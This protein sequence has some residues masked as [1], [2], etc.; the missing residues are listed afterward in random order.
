MDIDNLVLPELKH[1]AKPLDKILL[2]GEAIIRLLEQYPTVDKIERVIKNSIGESPARATI[3]KHLVNVKEQI[4]KQVRL[5]N[6]INNE[7]PEPVISAFKILMDYGE[8]VANINL[9]NEFKNIKLERE[10][11]LAAQKKDLLLVEHLKTQLLLAHN[12]QDSDLEI[13][14]Q[15]KEDFTQLTENNVQKEK[16]NNNNIKQ[17]AKQEAQNQI[18][19]TTLKNEQ[20]QIKSFETELTNSKLQA[21][22]FEHERDRLIFDVELLKKEKADLIAKQ[23]A[24]KKNIEQMR[25]MMEQM[26][27]TMQNQIKES[28]KLALQK[29]QKEDTTQSKF[30]MKRSNLISSRIKQSVR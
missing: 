19:N 26:S 17:L 3:T 14:K 7:L 24:N 8:T 1:L 22:A 10:T 29:S 15:L 27:L 28:A 9:E 2:T 4:A 12:K 21:R 25:E 30:T 11:L 20:Q 23:Q 16:I 18:L 6:G 5:A 13:N